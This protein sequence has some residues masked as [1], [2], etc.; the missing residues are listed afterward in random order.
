M[1][2]LICAIIN[3][4][5]I[6]PVLE[7]GI[8]TEDFTEPVK[9]YFKWILEFY[10]KYKEVPSKEAFENQFTNVKIEATHDP[11]QFFIDKFL[12]QVMSTK[13]YSGL[14]TAAG[15]LNAQDG[16]GIRKASEYLVSF[17][18]EISRGLLRTQDIGLVS[19]ILTDI[20]N[21]EVKPILELPWM[22][23]NK[24]L[25]GIKQGEF[26]VIAGRPSVG[27]TF[28]ALYILNQWIKNEYQY[29]VIVVSPEMRKTAILERLL[30]MVY[31]INIEN[32][33]NRNQETMKFL[34]NKVNEWSTKPIRIYDSIHDVNQL[35]VV[36]TGYK[37]KLVFIDSVYL[38]RDSS[39]NARTT[40]LW[41]SISGVLTKIRNLIAQYDL[42]VIATTQLSRNTDEEK[43]TATL[44]DISY[45]DA[46]SQL[47]DYIIGVVAN[48]ELRQQNLRQLK[49]IKSRYSSQVILNIR[50]R[51]TPKIDFSEVGIANAIQLQDS[52][53]NKVLEY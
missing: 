45:T 3:S 31:G 42:A 15:L 41:E 50:Y 4:K 21:T 39:M 23:L 30:A 20:L 6:S 33:R 13:L 17:G 18:Q 49:V 40:Q 26:W 10:N 16:Q 11:L 46:F 28:L 7:A 35:S 22:N 52:D 9:S 2:S 5:Q 48:A 36:I 44:S 25:G 53:I 24:I 32:I 38:L 43:M 47:A 14:K 1:F 51:F 37:P 29:P 34:M 27:K 19:N 12:D 8:T